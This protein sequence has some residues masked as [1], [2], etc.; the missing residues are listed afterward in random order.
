MQLF[1]RPAEAKDVPILGD[2]FYRTVSQ[3]AP[4]LYTAKQ[5]EAWAKSPAD[6]ERFQN[7]ILHPHTIIAYTK[8]LK[9]QGF[10]GI[11]TN[12]HI[13]SLY[14]AP[15]STRQGVGSQ[16]LA[17][18]IDYAHLQGI[19]H[20]HSEASFFS[21]ELFLRFG[22]SIAAQEKVNYNGAEFLRYKVVLSLRENN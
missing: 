19:T 21:K 1:F 10:S 9:I 6:T 18:I 7:W 22:F 12:G 20:L 13:S 8:D 11:E 5:V 15:E 17:K 14:V 4:Q 3:L 16:L 2:I